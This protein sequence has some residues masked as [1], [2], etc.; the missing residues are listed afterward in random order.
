MF[1]SLVSIIIVNFNG[2]IFLQKCLTSVLKT[3]YSNIEVIVV[4]NGSTDGSSELLR[5]FS[6]DSRIK[7]IMNEKNLGFAQGNNVGI[8]LAA[9]DY[10]VFL[11]NDTIVEP[12]WITEFVKVLESNFT[13]GAAQSKLLLLDSPSILDCAGNFSDFYAITFARGL[14]EKDVGKYECDE[15]F[16]CKGASMI[17]RRKV[18]EQVGTFD[19]DFFTYYEDTDLC[20]RIRLAGY[21]ILY[22]P[23]SIVYHKGSGSIPT[24][25]IK[26]LFFQVYLMKRNRITTLLKNYEIQNLIKYLSL[27]LV[28]E[29]SQIVIIGFDNLLRGKDLVYSKEASRAILWN[30]KHFQGIWKKRVYIQSLVR[31]VSD[32]DIMCK[33][34]VRKR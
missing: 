25:G 12:N 4:D 28:Y 7:L 29:C 31:R 24:V 2:E 13:I 33:M 5:S 21:K 27:S 10:V 9:G 6:Y 14:G 19:S 30:L 16:T 26:S 8:E 15:I 11:N 3:N 18:I 22:V 1:D 32:Q 20:W 17:V 23:T 34:Q